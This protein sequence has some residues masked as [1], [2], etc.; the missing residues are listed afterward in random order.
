MIAGGRRVVPLP[1]PVTALEDP[2]STVLH[3]SSVSRRREG[4]RRVVGFLAEV[5][6][7]A[8]GAGAALSVALS[9]AETVSGKGHDALAAVPNLLDRYR[10]AQYVA[11]H[12][13]EIQAAVDY[14]NRHAPDRQELEDTT[15][16]STETLEGLQTLTG[17]LAEAREDLGTGSFF[18]RAGK[19]PEALDHL[20]DAWEARPDPGSIS[21]LADVAE[22]VVPFVD[23]VEVLIPVF[24]GGLLTVADNF[25]SDEIAGTLLVMGVAFAVAY[26]LGTACGFWARRGRPGFIA[27]TLQRGGARV[28]RGWYVRHLE[29][30][31]GPALY[32]AAREHVQ[33]EIVTNPQEALDAHAL[34]ELEAYFRGRPSSVRVAAGQEPGVEPAAGIEPTT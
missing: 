15:Q 19:V 6:L 34:E 30:A 3:R 11:E 10:D 23:Q 18:E 4:G 16:R 12:R 8:Y 21:D 17:E 20:A 5:G 32:A 9:D 2:M 33:R 27:H 24:Y 14:V 22:R 31:L 29:Y 25:A 7:K 28:F 26:V 13:E 1:L